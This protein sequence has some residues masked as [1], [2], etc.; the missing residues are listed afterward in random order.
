MSRT[1][2]NASCAASSGADL[3]EARADL[4]EGN[5]DLIEADVA[6]S[7]GG[8]ESEQ[9]E[10]RR[11]AR[12]WAWRRRLRERRK[13]YH[14]YRAGVAFL[15]LTIIILGLILVPLPGPGWLIVFLGVGVLAS[16]FPWARR[17]HTFASI[18]LRRWNAWM[19]A[20]PWWVRIS[21][22]LGTFVFV[23]ACFWILFKLA[24]L[25]GFF[26]EWTTNFLHT[27]AAL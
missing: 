27:Y 7:S 4:A 3:T 20:S 5:A 9:S 6:E 8:G 15:G 26:P 22:A 13:T 25:P 11:R 14:V 10:Q 19:L 1:D 24:G 12:D 18:Q 2:G 17:L 21:V 16:E 23:C